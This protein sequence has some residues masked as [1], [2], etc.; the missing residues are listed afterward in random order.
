MSLVVDTSIIIAVITNE[1]SKSNLIKITGGEDLVAPLSLHWEIGNAISAMFKRMKIDLKTSRKA[2]EYYK[3]IPIRLIDVD[4]NRSIEISHK[5]KI[6][7]YD[8]YFLECAKNYGSS[9]LTLDKGLSVVAK[10]M[11]INV[12]EV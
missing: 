5:Y 12:I 7:C 11:N 4:I 8:A 10:Q 6:Y 9:L 3:M 2:I 1:N